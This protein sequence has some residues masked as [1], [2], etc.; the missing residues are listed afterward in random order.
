MGV[1]ARERGFPEGKK[2]F[3]FFPNF[4]PVL[5]KQ[6]IMAT[7]SA[8][9]TLGAALRRAPAQ[10]RGARRPAASAYARRSLSATVSASGKEVISTDKSPAALGPYSQA[11]KVRN[12]AV[13]VAMRGDG[14]S[15]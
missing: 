10:L 5:P 14:I 12:D 7:V 9:I 6:Q 3:P 1:P 13:A 11:I 8:N 15:S 4:I 2:K